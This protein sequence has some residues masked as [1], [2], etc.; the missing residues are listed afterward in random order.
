MQRQYDLKSIGNLQ[1]DH[2][3][4]NSYRN[5]FKASKKSPVLAGLYSAAIPGAGKLYAGKKRQALNMFILNAALGL[6][7][8]NRITKPG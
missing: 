4:E 7:A 5:Y 8:W 1:I 2:A 6:Q 3:I